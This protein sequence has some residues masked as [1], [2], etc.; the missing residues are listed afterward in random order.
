MHDVELNILGPHRG[1]TVGVEDYFEQIVRFEA[2]SDVL[3]TAIHL[4][5]PR[6]YGVSQ[7][8]FAQ[9]REMIEQK[10]L[11][12]EF[13]GPLRHNDDDAFIHVLIV[14]FAG[15]PCRSPHLHK[16]AGFCTEEKYP[17]IL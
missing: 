5:T 1:L 2:I 11:E 3:I 12:P 8:H 14:T 17:T 7:I 9:I 16:P 13:I 10:V 4:T 15:P 6:L